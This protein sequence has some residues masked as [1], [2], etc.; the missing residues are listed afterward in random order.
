MN[1]EGSTDET[2]STFMHEWERPENYSSLGK[3]QEAAHRAL[4]ILGGKAAGAGGSEKVPPMFHGART[5]TIN[6]PSIPKTLGAV[7][8]MLKKWG[9]ELKVYE[10]A[11]KSAKGK[12]SVQHA[13]E[14]NI[15]DIEKFIRELQHERTK[16]R[17]D[18]VK[19]RFGKKLKK[20]FGKITGF[21]T[22]IATG[23]REVEKAEQFAQQL[24]ALEPE[25]KDGQ[26]EADFLA[27]Y[28]AYVGGQERSAFTKV[29][30]AEG[31]LRNIILEGESFADRKERLWEKGVRGLRA[32]IQHTKDFTDVV[33]KRIADWKQNHPKEAFPEWLKKQIKER[34]QLQSWLP[35]QKFKKHELEET[36]GSARGEFFGLNSGRIPSPPTA[37]MEGSGSFEDS[38][39]SLQGTHWPDQHESIGSLPG[40]PVAGNYGGMIW[41][42][43]MAIQELGLKIK[44]AQSAAAAGEEEANSEHL[45]AVEEQL[46]RERKRVIEME[47]NSN[48][49]A[50]MGGVGAMTGASSI[51]WG[52][53]YASG[54]IVRTLVGETGPEIADLPIGTKVHNAGETSSMMQPKVEVYVHNYGD[55]TEAEVLVDGKRMDAIVSHV[56]NKLGQQATHRAQGVSDGKVGTI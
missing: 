23:Q 39:V 38:L 46:D 8:S 11:A 7:N 15:K 51:P 12:P 16:L 17:Q 45:A 6:F 10:R 21:D 29:L 26:S 5:G 47:I 41:D 18:E 36:I 1:A 32:D 24:V 25:H 34:D 13:L 53:R 19:K 27:E 3:R 35:V 43:Q 31:G 42:T 33:N 2:T 56:T 54:G 49:L 44:D 37:P 14:S 9:R 48:V 22:R 4:A 30:S 28:E 52:G 40:A 20:A 55:H 50:G